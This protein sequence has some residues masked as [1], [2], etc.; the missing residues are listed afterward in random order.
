MRLNPLLGRLLV[1]LRSL[2]LLLCLVSLFGFAVEWAQASPPSKAGKAVLILASAPGAIAETFRNL[3]GHGFEESLT[4][5][6][7]AK[8]PGFVPV[9]N[10][11]R[12]RIDGLVVRRGAGTLE[13]GWRML[14]GIFQIDGKPQYAVLALNPDLAIEHIWTIGEDLLVRHHFSIGQAPY[15]HGFALLPDGSMLLQFDNVFMPLRIDACGKRIW[16]GDARTTHAISPTDDGRF[17]WAVGADDDIRMFDLA[18]GKTVRDITMDQ[19]RAANPQISAFE[20]RRVDDNALGGDP[21][22][23]AGVYLDDPYHI[24]DVGPLPAALAPAFPQFAAGDL[25]ISFRSLNLVAV[26][27][28]HTLKVKWLTNDF[29]LRQHDADWEA[30][31]RI[32]V[33]DNQNGRQFSRIVEF[34]PADGTHSVRVDGSRYDFYSRIRG[35]QQ[36]LPGD[37]ILITSSQRGRVFELDRQGRVAFDMLVRDPAKPGMNF[38]VSQANW[39]DSR[40]PSFEKAL[41]CPAS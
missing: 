13:T 14:Y 12:H 6:K 3:A 29:T 25:L 39:Y 4:P 17:A 27:D 26:V 24:N 22:G 23:D 41:S 32:S 40:P 33:F 35:K 7:F 18:S 21:Q 1:G 5:D 20:M 15:P 11:T 36:A 31:G 2:F 28:P 10:R 38:V 37:G 19:L 16:A 34:D 9:A 30:N 8:A